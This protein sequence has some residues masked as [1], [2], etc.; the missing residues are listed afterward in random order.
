MSR[1]RSIGPARDQEPSAFSAILEHLCQTLGIGLDAGD[2]GETDD[3][4]LLPRAQYGLR[5]SQYVEE[6]GAFE[7]VDRPRV[8]IGTR[9]KVGA[10]HG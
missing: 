4:L 1:R 2:T 3:V 5:W 6:N 8:I 9:T 10:H 7:C